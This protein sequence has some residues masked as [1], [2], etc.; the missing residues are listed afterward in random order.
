MPLQTLGPAQEPPPA[1]APEECPTDLPEASAGPAPADGRQRPPFGEKSFLLTVAQR[2]KEAAAAGAA[3]SQCCMSTHLQARR[4]TAALSAQAA[5]WH[6]AGRGHA[7]FIAGE[8]QVY[9][10]GR[11]SPPEHASRA[12]DC[13]SMQAP[14]RAAPSRS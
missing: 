8:W 5:V 4:L 1:M 13:Q 12:K 10:A 2:A 3:V 7:G 14:G 6:P 11:G 9:T